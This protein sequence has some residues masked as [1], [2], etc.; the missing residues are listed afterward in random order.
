MGIDYKSLYDRTDLKNR[1]RSKPVTDAE[2]LD[3]AYDSSGSIIASGE[4]GYI[5]GTKAVSSIMIGY[6]IT[7]TSGFHLSPVIK[8]TWNKQKDINKLKHFYPSIQKLK[9]S[10]DIA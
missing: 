1:I 4:V 8:F 6:R 3:R 5:A 7:N 9:P 10:L 2:G